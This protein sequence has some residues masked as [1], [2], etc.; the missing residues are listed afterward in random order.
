MQKEVLRN[1]RK[2][3]ILNANK[4]EIMQREREREKK[5][6]EKNVKFRKVLI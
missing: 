6:R 2:I 5:N 3:E 4:D 1:L